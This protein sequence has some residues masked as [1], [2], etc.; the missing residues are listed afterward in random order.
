VH[1]M[2]GYRVQGRSSADA[3]LLL[4]DAIA[5]TEA[6][7]FALVLEGIPDDL[8]G[9]ITQ[10]VAVPTIGIGAGPSCD[11][12][13]LVFHDLVGLSGRPPPR[14]ARQYADLGSQAANALSAWAADV[15]AGRFPGPGESYTRR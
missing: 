2:G 8:A 14:F 13:V 5:I 6:G 12:Q 11:G 15:R 4:E 10:V 7:C 9:E 3:K 1:V